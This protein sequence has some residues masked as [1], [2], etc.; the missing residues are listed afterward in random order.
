M[1]FSRVNLVWVD[2]IHDVSN[3]PQ[4]IY[5]FEFSPDGEQLLVTAGNVILIYQT[6]GGTMIDMLKGH[7]DTVY[8]LSYC[9]DGRFCKYYARCGCCAVDSV[10]A[11]LIS[12]RD[13]LF[14]SF[15]KK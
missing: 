1:A 15:N 6:S 4:R 10:R 2:K 5:A 12:E 8:C 14:K 3:S 11:P 7:K 9:N 13:L